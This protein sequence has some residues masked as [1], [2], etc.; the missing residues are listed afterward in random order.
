MDGS[1]A[2]FDPQLDGEPATLDRA[3]TRTP[4][5]H[6]IQID[7]TSLDNVLSGI[8]GDRPLP[9]VRREF[10]QAVTN[11]LE[12]GKDRLSDSALRTSIEVYLNTDSTDPIVLAHD[13]VVDLQTRIHDHACQRYKVECGGVATD[14]DI[15]KAMG[16]DVWFWYVLRRWIDSVVVKYGARIDRISRQRA[17]SGSV[18]V[19]LDR[20]YYSGDIKYPTDQKRVFQEN[21]IKYCQSKK[22]SVGRRMPH[23][24]KRKDK[25]VDAV[26]FYNHTWKEYAD[27]GMLFRHQLRDYDLP[28]VQAIYT[29]CSRQ[30]D[31]EPDDILPPTR[32]QVV[33][34]LTRG[35]GAQFLV[36][37]G[38]SL[39]QRQRRQVRR[40][41]GSNPQV[42]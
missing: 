1:S 40:R 6:E 27:K 19:Y 28:L 22:V 7:R 3:D 39:A 25:S 26:T 36:R 35:V 13:M 23:Y 42:A 10:C 15:R 18:F 29:F 31:I 24:Q 9:D 16:K 20:D 38:K 33:D 30:K 21:A 41:A 5:Q 14:G 8:K 34:E 11:F 32:K 12:S 4:E 2:P 17:D 37:A